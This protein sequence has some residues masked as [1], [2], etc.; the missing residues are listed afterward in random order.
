MQKRLRGIGRATISTRGGPVR[1]QSVEEEGRQK[2]GRG[3]G[4]LQK[5][6]VLGRAVTPLVDAVDAHAPDVGEQEIRDGRR[7]KGADLLVLGGGLQSGFGPSVVRWRVS[8]NRDFPRVSPS[9][10]IS[11]VG[12][13]V[14]WLLFRFTGR[15]T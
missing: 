1:L 6:R 13:Y 11:S 7:G 9:G 8:L 3:P 5:G 14:R 10:G 12:I 15:V 2:V 4:V